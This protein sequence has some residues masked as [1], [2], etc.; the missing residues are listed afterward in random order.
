MYFGLVRISQYP[1]VPVGVA[2]VLAWS[3]LLGLVY[4]I[5]GARDGEAALRYFRAV[6]WL[7]ASALTLTFAWSLVTAQ[8]QR[9]RA[10]FGWQPIIEMIVLAG[11]LL[12]TMFWM[13]MTY[14]QAKLRD[15]RVDHMAK[16]A[17]DSPRETVADEGEPTHA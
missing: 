2:V 12:F 10:Q 6:M 9:F 17:E 1:F 13:G 11:L 8:L 4:A 14:V 16:A 7:G 15:D 5:G 3:I